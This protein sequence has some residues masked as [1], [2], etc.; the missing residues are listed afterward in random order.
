MLYEI[1]KTL[2]LIAAILWAGGMVAG[3]VLAA[4]AA[5][6]PEVFGWFRRW[7][8]PAMILTLLFGLALAVTSGQFSQTWLQ[9]KL[10]LVLVL[11]GLHGSVSGALRRQTDGGERAPRGL[12]WLSFGAIAGIVSLAVSK[13]L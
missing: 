12:G 8:S 9:A 4:R 13:R 3:G 6:T 2:H 1:L 10:M 7:V 11:T 5:G